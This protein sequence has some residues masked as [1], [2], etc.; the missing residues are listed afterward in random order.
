M[1]KKIVNAVK[2]AEFLDVNVQRVYELCRTD[3]SFPHIRIG[4]RQYRFSLDA[5]E[6]WVQSG[7]SNSGGDVRDRN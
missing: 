1:Q 4:E 7:G 2:V 5:L 6:R 3:P